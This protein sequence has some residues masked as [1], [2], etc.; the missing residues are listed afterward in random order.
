MTRQDDLNVGMRAILVDWLVEVSNQ[1]NI[2]KKN[3]IP[4][5]DVLQN[6]ITSAS[7][8]IKLPVIF[9]ISLLPPFYYATST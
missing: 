3:N 7:F 9:F 2:K 8:F 1:M 6:A 5:H 4:N